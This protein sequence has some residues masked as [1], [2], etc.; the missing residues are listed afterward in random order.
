MDYTDISAAAS[1][2]AALTELG[3]VAVAV[4]GLYVAIRG[5]RVLLGF[6]RR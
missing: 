5:A 1:W 3:T 2:T 6:I 4:A